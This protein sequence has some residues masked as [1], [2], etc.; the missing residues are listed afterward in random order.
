[1]KILDRLTGAS[2]GVASSSPNEAPARVKALSFQSRMRRL[3]GI[4][5]TSWRQLLRINRG[6]QV[7][8]LLSPPLSPAGF[9]ATNS[10]SERNIIRRML[11][12]H[13]SNTESAAS[14][15]RSAGQTGRGQSVERM[16]TLLAE[17]QREHD[18][19]MAR[20]ARAAAKWQ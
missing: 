4:R 7:D 6:A 2:A 5:P 12:N 13:A 20:S 15:D 11:D 19:L 17:G 18:N 9:S 8:P 16:L 14:G 1:M 10:A 3:S